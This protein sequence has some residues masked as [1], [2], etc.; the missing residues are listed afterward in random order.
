[1]DTSEL[2]RLCRSYR[3]FTQKP[4]PEDL[5]IQA[6][7]NARIASSASNQQVLRYVI[8]KSPEMVAAMQPLVAWAAKLPREI[9]TPR[10][11]RQP[12]AFIA[13]CYEGE[14]T[15]F[16][17]MDLGIAAQTIAV[18]CC[19]AGIGT[20]MMGAINRPAITKLLDLPETW[21]LKLA[22]ALGYP[23]H[24]CTVVDAPSNAAFDDLAYYVDDEE[25]F[26]VPKR[27]FADIVR[28]C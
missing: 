15:S 3:R 6:V 8:V 16:A 12:T 4:V 2:F 27:L 22:I 25:N 19:N 17:M 13:I 10:E 18:T 11:D 23:A 9:G 26:Y 5:I 20:C 1:M 21:N 14:E 28:T 7:E 24:E